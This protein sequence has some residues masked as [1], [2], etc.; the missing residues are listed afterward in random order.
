[1]YK[2]IKKNKRKFFFAT[3]DVSLEAGKGENNL[4]HISSS[5]R[6]LSVEDKIREN[7]WLQE[8]HIIY[9]SYISESINRKEMMD[10]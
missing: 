7:E 9:N 5:R 2:K 1:M 4:Q 10:S 3:I 8:Y 6:S